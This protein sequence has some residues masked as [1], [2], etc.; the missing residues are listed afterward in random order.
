[1]SEEK[2]NQMTRSV[3]SYRINEPKVA[4]Q[5]MDGEALLI[6]FE[7]GSYYSV[8]AVGT[9]ILALATGGTRSV[10]DVV[11]GLAVRYD[12]SHAA[13]EEVVTTFLWRLMDEE[14]IMADARN[15]AAAE[16]AATRDAAPPGP[17]ASLTTPSLLK[18]T[19]LE[20]LLK[21]DPIHDVDD[22]GWPMAKPA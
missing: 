20:D 4:I 1:M 13:I 21:L 8:D 16:A 17:R 9:E 3:F 19:D 14:L 11:D 2:W 5:I 15:P 10:A 6:D 22:S 18:F 7:R 12:A